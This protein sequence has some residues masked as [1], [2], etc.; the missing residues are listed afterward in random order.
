MPPMLINNMVQTINQFNVDFKLK[1]TSRRGCQQRQR[2]NRESELIL[3][4]RA[5]FDAG[6]IVMFDFFDF[7]DR[8]GQV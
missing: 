7:A 3:N 2:F 1:M 8:V 6:G 5:V 4:S